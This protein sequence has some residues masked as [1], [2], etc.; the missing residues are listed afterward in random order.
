MEI[1]QELLIFLMM[2]SVDGKLIFLIFLYYDRLKFMSRLKM[3]TVIIF[4]IQILGSENI[5]IKTNHTDL[6]H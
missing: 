6:E 2:E 4:D 3:H 1:F 5:G